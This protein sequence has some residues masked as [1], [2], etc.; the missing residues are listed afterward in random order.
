MICLS[1]QS[2]N[3]MSVPKLYQNDYKKR[4][5]FWTVILDHSHNSPTN[6]TIV[7][8]SIIKFQL[9]FILISLTLVGNKC[10]QDVKFKL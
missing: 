7:I 4:C 3:F 10:L 6:Y 5:N 9:E 8:T 2:M 1:L